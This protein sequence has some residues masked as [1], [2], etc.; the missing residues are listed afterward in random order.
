MQ[1]LGHSIDVLYHSSPPL[2]P[3]RLFAD[4]HSTHRDLQDEPAV[5]GRGNFP[6]TAPGLAKTQR[7]R[8]ARVLRSEFQVSFIL[9]VLLSIPAIHEQR[10]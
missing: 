8:P 9:L 1:L 10:L 2:F 3:C 7:Q 4:Q 6:G 5:G